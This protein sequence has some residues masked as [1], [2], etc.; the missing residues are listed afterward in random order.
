MPNSQLATEEVATK[1]ANDQADAAKA[2]EA[3]EATDAAKAADTLVYAVDVGD[4]F[5]HQLAKCGDGMRV[6]ILVEPTKALLHKLEWSAAAAAR[7]PQLNAL[8][9]KITE[10]WIWL[11]DVVELVRHIGHVANLF[12][13]VLPADRASAYRKLHKIKNCDNMHI[14][15]GSAHSIII[16][17]KADSITITDASIVAV[18]QRHESINIIAPDFSALPLD[19]VFM[20]MLGK[21]DKVYAQSAN[22]DLMQYLLRRERPELMLDF[23]QDGTT[24]A[25]YSGARNNVIMD[26]IR[27]PRLMYLM[28]GDVNSLNVYYGLVPNDANMAQ[29]L[30]QR[31]LQRFTMTEA[32]AADESRHTN[33]H[34][35]L[36]A[37]LAQFDPA[38]H[39][40]KLRS[41]E[42]FVPFLAKSK[43]PP[44]FTRLESVKAFMQSMIE[45]QE[46]S[47]RD[48]ILLRKLQR[49]FELK[50]L[51]SLV[52]NFG[53]DKRKCA[54]S[55]Y[56]H[57]KELD[58][59]EWSFNRVG[60]KIVGTKV[61]YKL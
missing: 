56:A 3:T 22:Y 52:L 28:P 57:L 13:E 10:K 37:L 23:V 41:F 8:R 21:F 36:L 38:I 17:F 19:D 60:S 16:D 42:A 27:S 61:W 40:S 32:G 18:A 35:A 58:M 7:I 54:Y 48:F 55:V 6:L 9:L 50:L 31:A 34:H 12:V 24:A 14:V 53:P 43:M 20:E 26:V 33:A 47:V 11:D 51:T 1:A 29:L 30:S 45:P 59:D 5:V 49:L 15:Y 2:T 46:A 25:T 44:Y 4:T 39:W